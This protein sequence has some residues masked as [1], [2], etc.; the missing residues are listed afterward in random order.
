MHCR[1]TSLAGVGARAVLSL[2]QELELGLHVGV[3]E[4]QGLHILQ[5][6]L[7][8]VG[9][10]PDG[11]QGGAQVA[12]G[13]LMGGHYRETGSSEPDWCMWGSQARAMLARNAWTRL[14]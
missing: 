14:R 6:L 2:A 10:A 5:A 9:E 1:L 8:S 11:G 4:E 3:V 12:I 13:V 7:Q